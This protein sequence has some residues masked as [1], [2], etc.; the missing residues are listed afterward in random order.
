LTSKRRGLAARLELRLKYM[1]KRATHW[2][3]WGQVSFNESVQATLGDTLD[4]L[5]AIFNVYQQALAADSE[6]AR[7]LREEMLREIGVGI[8]ALVGEQAGQSSRTEESAAL[9]EKLGEQMALWTSE[10]TLLKTELAKVAVLYE[11]TVAAYAE[12]GAEQRALIAHMQEEHRVM[13]RQISLEAGEQAVLA[14][15]AQRRADAGIKVLTERLDALER[16]R[17]AVG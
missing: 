4:A 6:R 1:F 16:E 9:L 10:I 13:F 2:F 15:R 17:R 14:D 3:T 12:F 7:E 11:Q 5:H 8:T